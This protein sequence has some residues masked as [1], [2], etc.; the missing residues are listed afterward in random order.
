MNRLL[1]FAGIL[2][3]SLASTSLLALTAL[4]TQGPESTMQPQSSY[5]L[6]VG[7][8]G[9]N[10]S[11]AAMAIPASQ[12]ETIHLTFIYADYNLPYDNPHR[13]IV[14]GG[15][16]RLETDTVNSTNPKTG[17]TLT[18]TGG[19]LSLH[20][21][22]PSVGRNNLR[23]WIVS[24]ASSPTTPPQPNPLALALLGSGVLLVFSIYGYSLYQVFRVQ[25]AAPA[26]RRTLPKNLTRG[27]L[28]A[29]ATILAASLLWL[30]LPTVYTLVPQT[31]SDVWIPPQTFTLAS[32]PEY[33]VS[34][35]SSGQALNGAIEA[36][37]GI[38]FHIMNSTQ[39]RAWSSGVQTLTVLSARDVTTYRFSHTFD[40][41]DT[42]YFV[43]SNRGDYSNT[44]SFSVWRG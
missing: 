31:V 2:G 33:I 9:F 7:R 32:R 10:G 42:Y 12:G 20:C 28:A 25:A 40:K 29:E 38:D 18:V 22:Y 26:L 1:F 5:T 14:E 23:G 44:V 41:N 30:Y 11:S 43:F 39:Y 19:S 27:L 15:G 17:I 16:L 35:V 4:A 6:L 34:Y 24:E 21:N 37:R 3:A 13:I 8:N 36:G